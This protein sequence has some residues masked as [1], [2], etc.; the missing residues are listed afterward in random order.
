MRSY[1]PA[2]HDLMEAVISPIVT[3]RPW[4]Y[5]IECLQAAM[6]FSLL[7]CPLPRLIR[8]AYLKRLLLKRN[9]KRLLFWSQAG[10]NTLHTY[11]KVDDERLLA[12]TEVVYPAIRKVPD[13]LIRF[14]DRDVNL[15]FS[16]DFFRKGGVNVLDAFER[17]QRLYPSIKLR[18]CSDEKIDFNTPDTALRAEC[19]ER[20]RKNKGILFG[21]VQRDDLIRDILPQTDVYLLPTYCETFGFALLEAMAFGIPVIATNHFAIPEVVEHGVCGFLID[22]SRF[23]CERHFRGY[24]IRKIPADFR[25]HISEGVFKHLCQLIESAELRKSMG[26]AGVR[27]ARTKF[28]FETRNERMLKIY[29]EAVQ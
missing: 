19:L 20:I 6:A 4:I 22:T 9:M 18:L 8:L 14:N 5:S 27:L 7:G 23:N 24:V 15:L 21:R 10:K 25:E 12:K 16:G 13:H 26:M 2:D 11:G 3:D 28:S 29:R 1:E 17:A